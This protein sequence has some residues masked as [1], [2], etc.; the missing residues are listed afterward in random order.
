M[1]MGVSGWGIVGSEQLGGRSEHEVGES[2]FT[3]LL[4]T[5]YVYAFF[6]LL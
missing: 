2:G 5:Q 1:R 3:L 4:G 6:M